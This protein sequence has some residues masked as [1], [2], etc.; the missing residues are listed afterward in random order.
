ML[1]V[2]RARQEHDAFADTLAERGV[3]V[4]YLE[5]PAR[6]DARGS[7]RPRRGARPRTI[8]DAALGPRLGP[9]AARLAR[10]A[11]PPTG[12]PSDRRHHASRAAV[13]L[14][15]AGRAACRRSTA[16]CCR[17]F[18]TTSSPATRRRGCTTACRMNPMAKPAR[19]REAAAPRRRST[20]STRCS[21]AR[22]LRRLERRAR[23]P[24]ELEGGDMLVIGTA[25]VL[26]A[27][28]SAPARSPSSRSPSGCSR[29]APRR[30]DRRRDAPAALGHAPRHG[31]DDG[32]P[33][34]VHDLPGRP[35]RPRGYTLEPGDDAASVE[36]EPDVF[37]AIA[38]ALDLAEPA[39]HRHRRRPYEAEREQ[40]DDG[41]NVLAVAPGVVVAYERNVDT[42]TRLPARPASR[43]SPSPAPSSAGAGA[44]PAA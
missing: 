38:R 39:A 37:A 41:N 10:R 34:R 29:P 43:S 22:R 32:R 40:W 9:R 5:R 7:S 17:R 28:A 15:R 13:H 2:K 23:R 27:W 25:A 21:R 12:R 30:G 1:W 44:A 33:R 16:S 19:R 42:N 36:R 18:R 4:L 6:R 11:T 14:R 3:E 24:A 20:A 8:A 26:S 31:D 35:R